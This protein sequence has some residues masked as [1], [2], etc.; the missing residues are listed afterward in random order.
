MGA[1]RASEG[2]RLERGRGMGLRN[3]CES[4]SGLK[5]PD[6]GNEGWE[7]KWGWVGAPASGLKAPGGGNEGGEVEWGR[8]GLRNA[9]ASASEQR[10]QTAGTRTGKWIGGG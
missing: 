6:G 9:C 2:I 5:A 1:G 8:V 3:G 7:V 10:H 4:A